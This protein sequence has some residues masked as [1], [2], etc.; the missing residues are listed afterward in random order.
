MA[1]G[2]IGQRVAIARRRRGLSQAVV[3]GLVGRSESWLSQ[4]ERDIRSVD[5][6][7]VLM[8]LAQVLHVEVDALLGRPWAF[9]PN[10]GS[11]ADGLA[12]VRHYL[13][14]YGHLLPDAEP[15]LVDMR[16]LRESVRQGHVDYQ[17]ARYSAVAAGLPTLLTQVD[18]LMRQARPRAFEATSLYVSGYVLA[19][20]L[21]RKLGALDLAMLASDRA[22]TWATDSA[23]VADRALAGYQVIESLLRGDQV[24]DAEHLVSML[25]ASLTYRAGAEEP[26]LL[27]AVGALWL[28]GAI[29]A[30]RR[31]D[32]YEALDRLTQAEQLAA[33]LG[34]DA[35]Y[36]WTAFGPTNVAIHRVSV[37]ADLG[38]AGEALVASQ[39]VNVVNLPEGLIG[40]RAQLHIDLAWA[41]AQGKRDA[42]A[43]LHLIE[44]EKVA[45]ERLRY[46][47]LVREHIREMLTRGK[48]G[49]TVL[50][51]LAV[52]SGVI[53]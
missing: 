12:P 16:V 18:G 27:S 47:P 9:A 45:P 29:I 28:L 23:S 14:G 33:R 26:E 7:S 39:N 8:D 4:V 43:T 10:G 30:A 34:R 50:H 24:E 32:K 41:Y 22:A 15:E 19:A 52:R 40:R 3:A 20:K 13:N 48:S 46:D 17:A 37:A 25:T 53:D 49:T 21:L 11:T 38:E 31:T 6:L 36:G 35:N 1:Q 2:S 44:A 51:D 5:R 42:D